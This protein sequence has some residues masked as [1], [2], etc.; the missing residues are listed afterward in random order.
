MWL[1]SSETRHENSPSIKIAILYDGLNSSLGILKTGYTEIDAT[2]ASYSSE[3][4]NMTDYYAPSGNHGS[5]IASLICS[6]CPVESLYIAK[7]EH[8]VTQTGTI[9]VKAAAVA[10]VKIGVGI[11]NMNWTN[12][13]NS[14]DEAPAGL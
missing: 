10:E 8:K 6:I 12:K 9:Q 3:A 5:R 4:N 14:L 11:I 1:L 2:I 7:V 13:T